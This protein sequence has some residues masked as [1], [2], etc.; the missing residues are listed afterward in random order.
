MN[1]SITVYNRICEVVKFFWGHL[2]LDGQLPKTGRHLA[3]A[4]C[5]ALAAGLLKQ[6]QNIETKKATYELL[7]PDCS[8]KTFVVSLNRLAKF[9]G[10]ILALILKTNRDDT[11]K[12]YRR[13][14]YSRLPQ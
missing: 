3:L 5:D 6:K 11:H 14:G 7:E 12:A 10:L 13:H 8:Y 1:L 4:P 2:K 9:A